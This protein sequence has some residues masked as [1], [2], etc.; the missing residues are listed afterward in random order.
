MGCGRQKLG[1]SGFGDGDDLGSPSVP[2]GKYNTWN[3]GQSGHEQDGNSWK[4][5][6]I[7]VEWPSGRLVGLR[8][9]EAYR[10]LT[11]PQRTRVREKVTCY[12]ILTPVTM[13]GQKFEILEDPSQ[14]C[15]GGRLWAQFCRIIFETFQN[16]GKK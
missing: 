15:L 2:W 5:E 4:R 8:Y 3:G 11:R 13:E 7:G 6:G 14:L 1:L 12:A 16:C 10:R 9:E